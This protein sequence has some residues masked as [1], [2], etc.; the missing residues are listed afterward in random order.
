MLSYIAVRLVLLDLFKLNF[1]FGYL[2]S[3][4]SLLILLNLGASIERAASDMHGVFLLS[5]VEFQLQ[6]L[7]VVRV[8]VLGV[9][10][11]LVELGRTV[12][13]VAF[14]FELLAHLALT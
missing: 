9:L 3:L 8:L 1:A 6:L 13:R 5:H 12:P 7:A 4:V 2:R 10:T 14:H 11:R